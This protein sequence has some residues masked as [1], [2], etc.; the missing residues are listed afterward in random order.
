MNTEQTLLQQLIALLVTVD[1]VGT[2]RE[3][4][5]FI[6][7]VGLTA[8]QPRIDLD[9]A[10]FTFVTDLLSVVGRDGRDTFDLFLLRLARSPYI[11]GLDRQAELNALIM[12]ANA[13]PDDAWRRAFATPDTVRRPL[14]PVLPAPPEQFIGR[15]DDLAYYREKLITYHLAVITGMAGIGKT[16]LA[17]RLAAEFPEPERVFW[18]QF[19]PAAGVDRLIDRLAEFLA[20]H[21]RD[22]LWQQL[23]LLARNGGQRPSDEAVLAYLLELVRGGDFVLCLDDFHHADDDPT[24]NQLVD[25]LRTV[26]LTGELTVIITSRRMPAFVQLV[27][28]DPLDGLIAADVR[29]LLQLRGIELTEAQATRLHQLTGGNAEFVTLASGALLAGQEIDDLFGRMAESDDVRRYLI[30]N[31][32]QFLNLEERRVM[33]AVAVLSGYPGARDIIEYLL[34]GVNVY[35][36]LHNLVWLHLL[37]EQP[38]GYRQHD[39]VQAFYYDYT[40]PL[41]RRRLHRRAARFYQEEQPD[42]LLAGHHLQRAGDSVAAARVLVEDVWSIIN[43]GQAQVC[44]TLLQDIDVSASDRVLA[45]DV[46][47]ALAQVWDF[48]GRHDAARANLDK[49]LGFAR[50]VSRWDGARPSLCPYL[51]RLRRYVG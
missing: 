21:G 4:R 46:A 27:E 12:A 48:I 32:N 35:E 29:A 8:L 47:L 31:V 44:A 15:A 50:L 2:A 14:R 25:R 9:G 37:W 30:A 5:G 1:G 3:R 17:L 16:S 22:A 49:A 41:Q 40:S 24:L 18:H 19:M 34:D 42:T 39:I 45:L 33:E 6:T 13:L 20:W 36:S 38:T 11:G 10:P 7:H 51:S 43:Q 28:F 26:V 23:Q